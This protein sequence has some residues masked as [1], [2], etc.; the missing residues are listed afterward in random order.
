MQT[1]LITAI[2]RGLIKLS[3]AQI[4]KLQSWGVSHIEQIKGAPRTAFIAN[5]KP[6]AYLSES[7][8]IV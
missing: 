6:V 5:G 4:K 1:P 7:G 8:K 2:E 3:A